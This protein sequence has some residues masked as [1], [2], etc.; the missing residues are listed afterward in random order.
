MKGSYINVKS[1]GTAESAQGSQGFGLGFGD[2]KFTMG[3][4]MPNYAQ[5]NW[6]WR[7]IDKIFWYKW[8][9]KLE[10]LACEADALI[11]TPRKQ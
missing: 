2:Q 9:L 7:K 3:L 4:I 8:D 5:K 10:T 1:Q 6:F 11:T